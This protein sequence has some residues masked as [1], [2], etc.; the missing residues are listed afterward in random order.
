MMPIS[1]DSFD[2][3]GSA[4]RWTLTNSVGA[5]VQVIDYGATITSFRVPGRDGEI[6]DV[7][8]GYDDFG[9]VAAIAKSS[10]NDVSGT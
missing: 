9:L 2:S 7:V 8:L 3:D 10:F 5:S 1:A 4:K 6:L